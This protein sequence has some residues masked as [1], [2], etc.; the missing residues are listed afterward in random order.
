MIAAMVP[1]VVTLS[2]GVMAKHPLHV[3]VADLQK[4]AR[5]LTRDLGIRSKDGAA[6]AARHTATP[7]SEPATP[8]DPNGFEQWLNAQMGETESV[9]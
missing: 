4:Q 5:D 8:G 7:E 1:H 9:H 3:V 2:N 6:P